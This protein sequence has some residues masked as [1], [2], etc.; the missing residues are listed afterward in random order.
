M[1]SG[2][3]KAAALLATLSLVALLVGFVYRRWFGG[4][5]AALGDP[6]G[7]DG[8]T[9]YEGTG[10]LAAEVRRTAADLDGASYERVRRRFVPLSSRLRRQ[11]RV[12]PADAEDALLVEVTAL[13]IDCQALGMEHSRTEAVRTGIFLE[14]RL[15][16]VEREAAALESAALEASATERE[17]DPPIRSRRGGES[18]G[19]FDSR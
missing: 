16:A 4:A 17:S 18:P 15:A 3:A 12:A 11:A 9:W 6:A 13:A 19:R 14:D 10:A 1:L 7:A 8:E 5:L 2:A